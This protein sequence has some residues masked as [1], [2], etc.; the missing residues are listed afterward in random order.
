ML[1][2]KYSELNSEQVLSKMYHRVRNNNFKFNIEKD[3][4]IYKKKRNLLSQYL[5]EGG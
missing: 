2:L 4:T 5:N 3:H 1:R